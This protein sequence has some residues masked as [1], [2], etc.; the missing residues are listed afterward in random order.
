MKH[1][2]P[3]RHWMRAWCARITKQLKRA[4][5]ARQIAARPGY[6]MRG[7]YVR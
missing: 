1:K 7:V 2:R 3:A 6:Y 5:I 4:K